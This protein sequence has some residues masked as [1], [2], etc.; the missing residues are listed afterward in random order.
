MCS[1]NAAEPTVFEGLDKDSAN[2]QGLC[3]F[4]LHISFAGTDANGTKLT[5][6]SKALYNFNDLGLD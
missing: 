6:S 2:K 4:R 5:T 1:E 3:D